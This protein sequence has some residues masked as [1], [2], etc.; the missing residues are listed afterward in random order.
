MG[1]VNGG[2]GM[3]GRDDGVA[4]GCADEAFTARGAAAA[5]DLRDFFAARPSRRVC[6]LL[7]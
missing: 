6:A 4:R 7:V 5:G 1:G 3:G 2:P